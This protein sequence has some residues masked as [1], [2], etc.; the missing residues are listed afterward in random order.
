MTL[1]L[2]L[3][4]SFYFNSVIAICWWIIFHPGFYSPDSL[5]YVEIAK[6]LKASS[7]TG[8]VFQG[9]LKLISFN[10]NLV[11]LIT[12]SNVLILAYSVTRLAFVISSPRIAF[13]SSALLVSSPVIGAIGITLWQDVPF[14][15]GLLLLTTFFVIKLGSQE[16]NTANF[17]SLFVPGIVLSS[18][19]PNGL[20]TMLLFL[21][22]MLSIKAKSLFTP[23]VGTLI[24]VAL[25]TFMPSLLLNKDVVNSAYAQ[26]WMRYDISCFAS[27]ERGQGFIERV[28]PEIGTTQEWESKEAC[29]WFSSA[30]LQNAKIAK[31]VRYLP[32]AWLKLVLEEPLFVL[33][34]H[35][36]RNSYLLPIPING[37]PNPPFIHTEIDAN[38]LELEW[39]FQDFAER[40]R[41][42]PRVWNFYNGIFAWS[43]LWLLFMLFEL[44]RGKKNIIEP[45]FCMS[46][47]VT[48]VLFLV[49]P[50]SDARYALSVLVSG[51]LLMITK[52]INYFHKAKEIR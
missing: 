8:I 20:F 28:R 50:I 4:K 48:L 35:S 23:L 39:T 11:S 17:I 24:G 21:A 12:L 3:R 1:N 16:S 19:R 34:V 49:A 45:V 15:A 41:F 40:A 31:S 43:G 10:G 36:L 44:L 42:I 2:T 22:F 37:I 29:T 25:L 7:T 9:Y 27:T 47:A 51:Q 46:F 5:Y 38:T 18:F 32:S 30:N 33:K 26:E 52:A 14:A 6:S 13:V